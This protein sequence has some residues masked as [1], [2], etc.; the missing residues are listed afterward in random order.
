ERRDP[1]D[2]LRSKAREKT[3]EWPSL[4]G[5]RLFGLSD[6]LAGRAFG[7]AASLMSVAWV[8]WLP[9]RPRPASAVGLPVS[10]NVS[11]IKG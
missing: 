4:A 1:L 8:P 3:A 5:G 10:S 6:V 9:P 2:P 11:L 7:P